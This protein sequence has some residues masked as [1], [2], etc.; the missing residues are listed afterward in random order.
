MSDANV[1]VGKWTYRSWLN[2]VNLATQPNDLLFGSGTIDIVEAPSQILKGTI[3]GSGWQ[4]NL[5]GSRS[6]GNPMT[7]RF[8]GKG[9]VSGAEWI[10]A[11]VGYLVPEWPDG[12]NQ[13]TAMVGSIVRVI[14]HPSGNGGVSPA[15]VTASWYAVKHG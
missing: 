10:Y 8:Q 9:L 11:Y 15:G 7:V 3:G 2:D 1:F 6:Y 4:L 13:K 5:H 14:P 12:V